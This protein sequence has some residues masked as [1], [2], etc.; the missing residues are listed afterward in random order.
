M[1]RMTRSTGKLQT[2]MVTGA[3]VLFALSLSAAAQQQ[4]SVA[5]KP[6][7]TMTTITGVWIEG[8][9]FDV[10]Y[11]GTS[12]GCAQ[13]CLGNPKCVMIEYYRPEKKCNLYDTVRPQK[14]GGSS[15]VGI[16]R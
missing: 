10:T 12:D 3:T 15:V 6:A 1:A 16:R 2:S 5:A 14:A 13:R 9:G 8:P 4:P 7:A 11:G